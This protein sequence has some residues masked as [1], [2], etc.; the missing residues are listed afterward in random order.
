MLVID[1]RHPHIHLLK[2]SLNTYVRCIGLGVMAD[3][4][5]IQTTRRQE[6]TFIIP[7]PT[8]HLL[9]PS[10]LKRSGK[11]YDAP[12]EEEEEDHQ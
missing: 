10:T 6:D 3:T 5:A 11:S 7:P 9:A 8:V 1:R 12:Q 2:T 4:W